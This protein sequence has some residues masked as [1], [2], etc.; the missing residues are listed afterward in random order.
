MANNN[1]L[2]G[3]RLLPISQT[4]SSSDG[5]NYAMEGGSHKL[6]HG[7]EYFQILKLLIERG[8]NTNDPVPKVDDE[9][10]DGPEWG[11]TR[12]VLQGILT[13][14]KSPM[15]FEI[16]RVVDQHVERDGFEAGFKKTNRLLFDRDGSGSEEE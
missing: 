15:V 11:S 12:Q 8:T 1:G 3:F 13:D 9:D 5:S 2:D 16:L 14:S 4:Q 7:L 6:H 10:F